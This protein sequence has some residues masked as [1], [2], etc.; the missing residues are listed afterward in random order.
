M[1]DNISK[2][3]CWALSNICTSS[4]WNGRVKYIICSPFVFVV[5]VCFVFFGGGCS[6]FVPF[7]LDKMNHSWL[8]WNASLL[9]KGESSPVHSLVHQATYCATIHQQLSSNTSLLFYSEVPSFHLWKCSTTSKNF[10]NSIK[11]TA[12][13]IAPSINSD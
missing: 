11:V 6:V 1:F 5:L 8:F 12:T 2:A 3:S 9:K 13:I 7:F 4:T 10:K